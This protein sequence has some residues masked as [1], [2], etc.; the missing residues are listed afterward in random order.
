MAFGK[1][2][3]AKAANLLKDSFGK[4]RS[5]PLCLH[6]CDQPFTMALHPSGAMPRGHV[7]PKL[8]RLTRRV[9]CSDHCQTHN[10]LLEERNTQSFFQHRLQ[11]WMGIFLGFLAVAA[12]QIGMDHSTGNGSWS[13]DA[14]FNNQIIEIFRLESRQHCHLRPAFDLKDSDR[15]A[16]AD[17]I[18]HSR[19]IS[20]DRHH[21]MI[22]TAML[23]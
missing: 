22:D 13:Y 6:A 3:F 2:I 7:A 19:V 15:I 14:D 8:V 4:L 1:A 9:V 10:L 20:R 11:T 21:G 5:N 23:S 17:H 12:P 16:L 18:E